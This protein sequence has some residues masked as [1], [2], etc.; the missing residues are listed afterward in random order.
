MPGY[1]GPQ[2]RHIKRHVLYQC[3]I[4]WRRTILGVPVGSTVQRCRMRNVTSRGISIRSATLP[5]IGWT[6]S[7]AFDVPILVHALPSEF[8]VSGRVVW[9]DE[10][11][12]RPYYRVGCAFRHLSGRKAQDLKQFIRDAVIDPHQ[13]RY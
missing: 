5:K 6:L 11:K 10:L 12:G 2:R 1:H 13:A 7:L 9:I 4:D 8:V 3:F